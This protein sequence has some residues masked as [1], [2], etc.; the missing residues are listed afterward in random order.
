MQRG[1]IKI[2]RKIEDSGLLQMHGTLALFMV[3][4]LRAAY[5]PCR[6]GLIDL[7][8]GQ[9]SAGRFQ[10]CEWSGLSEQSTRTSVK[11]LHDLGM[12]TSKPTNKFTIYTI[13]NYGQYQDYD[14][15]IN[16]QTNQQLTNNQPTTNQQLTTI[17]DIKTLSIKE[18]K[19][20]AQ[21]EKK[22]SIHAVK[23]S[24]ETGEFSNI[25]GQMVIWEKAY[26]AV[27]I[28]GELNK[29]ASW[30]IANPKN[31]KSNYARFLTNWL[32]RVQDKAPAQGGGSKP[33]NLED[34]MKA[35]S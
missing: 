33:S 16:Q 29:A 2:W 14:D 32:S 6:V 11:H 35:H 7:D 5:K 12:I 3:M 25:N 19:P 24:F 23:F 27:N 30:L 34:F 22:H 13:V 21:I 31:S 8:R 9:L 20:L 10:L 4:I 1:Y 17:K 28:Q 15:T 18:L 26:P